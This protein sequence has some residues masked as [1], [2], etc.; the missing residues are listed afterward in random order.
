MCETFLK[1]SGESAIPEDF[2]KIDIIEAQRY[3]FIYTIRFSW[4]MEATVD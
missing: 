3:C 4:W 2:I 1:E